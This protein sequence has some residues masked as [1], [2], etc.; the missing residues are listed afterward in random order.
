MSRKFLLL[1]PILILTFIFLYPGILFSQS[2]VSGKFPPGA[3]Y[4]FVILYKLEET[5]KEFKGYSKLKEDGSFK[6]KL[7]TSFQKGVY[8]IVYRLPEEKYFFDL[9]YDGSSAISFS[10]DEVSGLQFEKGINQIF[11]RYLNERIAIQKKIDEELLLTTPS[12]EV[13]GALLKDQAAMQKKNESLAEN[14]FAHPFI[15]ALKPFSPNTFDNKFKFLGAQRDHFFTH[16]DFDNPQLRAS[17]FPLEILKDYYT[18]TVNIGRFPY[19][20]AIDK[21]T[22]EVGSTGERFQKSLLTDFW[23]WLA[24]ENKVNPANHLAES[25]L[26]G[27]AESVQDTVLSKKLQVYRNLSLGARSPEFSW[28]EA[29]TEKSLHSLEGSAY[30]ILAFWNSGCSYC[31]EQLPLLHEKTKK[32][33]KS[34]VQVIAIGLEA[35]SNPWEEIVR[36][37]PDFIHVLKEKQQRL[38]I[39]EKYDIRATPTYLVLNKDKLI[40]AKPRGFENLERTIDAILQQAGEN[41]PAER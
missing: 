24:D 19:M 29:G 30:Y 34:T 21:I 5:A 8:R 26:I 38:K 27:L 3:D 37:F 4:E 31:T 16:F 20:S 18:S 40:V 14:T 23:N 28:E 13:I 33:P 11:Y 41:R 25:Y 2:Y 7:D 12:P 39:S 32:I 9:L 35:D 17:G 6:I 36:D 1:I 22:S 10:F 15:R